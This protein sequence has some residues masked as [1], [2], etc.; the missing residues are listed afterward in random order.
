MQLIGLDDAVAPEQAR[1]LVSQAR[2]EVTDGAER[3]R[4]V[5]LVLTTLVYKFPT[6]ER[7]AIKQMLGLDEL[8][9]TRF[10]QEIAEEERAEG[11]EEGREEAF[12]LAVPSFLALG[13]TV[14]QIAEAL[15]TDVATVERIIQQQREQN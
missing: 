8:K 9:Q 7:E 6:L 11:R 10:Y 12:A 2:A 4:V 15:K 13:L 3:E 1:R 5:E 14:E